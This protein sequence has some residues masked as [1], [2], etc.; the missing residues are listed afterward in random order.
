MYNDYIKTNNIYI[1]II[2]DINIL[3]IL[4]ELN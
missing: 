1:N 4:L 2:I 3:H